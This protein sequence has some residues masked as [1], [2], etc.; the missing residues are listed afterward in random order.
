MTYHRERSR[1]FCNLYGRDGGK[2][3]REH[4]GRTRTRG[5]RGR[6][7]DCR[8]RWARCD[9]DGHNARLA[10]DSTGELTRSGDVSADECAYQKA[11]AYPYA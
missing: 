6:G 5:A 2:A 9:G 4:A 1:R 8:R 11:L 3:E 10:R 7:V